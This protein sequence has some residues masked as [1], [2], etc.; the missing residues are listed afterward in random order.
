MAVQWL[1]NGY[2]GIATSAKNLECA[3]SAI[4]PVLC[5]NALLHVILAAVILGGCCGRIG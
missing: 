2:Y 5:E 1:T 3:M 4:D